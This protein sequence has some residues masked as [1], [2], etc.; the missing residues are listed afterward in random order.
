MFGYV[1]P[2]SPWKDDYYDERFSEKVEPKESNTDWDATRKRTFEQIGAG[3]NSETSKTHQAVSQ[4]PIFKSRAPADYTGKAQINFDDGIYIGFIERGKLSG[5]GIRI[6]NDGLIFK[7]HFENDRINGEGVAISSNNSVH[8]GQFIDGRANGKGIAIDDQ[9]GIYKG[10]FKDGKKDGEII[11]IA[12]GGSFV[13]GQFEEGKK[14]GKAI[15]IPN[16][17]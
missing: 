2:N 14:K 5:E 7:G 4:Y 13:K 17:Q 11:G 1:D 15:K 10:Q 16:G 9:G 6:R 3:S 8:K 12:S